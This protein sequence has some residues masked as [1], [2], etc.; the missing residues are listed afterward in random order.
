MA[1]LWRGGEYMPRKWLRW[2]TLLAVVLFITPLVGLAQDQFRRDRPSNTP[3]WPRGTIQVTNDWQ[4]GV[5][6]TLWSSQRERIGEWV[7]QPAARAF[8]DVDGNPIK[9]RPSYKIKI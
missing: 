7:L 9:V 4:D 1:T 6:L 5:R 3:S 8:L 2:Y